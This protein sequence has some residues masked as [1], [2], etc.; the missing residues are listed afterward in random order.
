L[1]DQS[2]TIMRTKHDALE[3][4][5]RLTENK[6]IKR[7]TEPKNTKQENAEI[8][9]KT[10]AIIKLERNRREKRKEKI[11]SHMRWRSWRTK[12]KS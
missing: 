3:L 2:V 1:H 10:C 6:E 5:K 9:L 8:L 11:L 12:R 4:H 7:K